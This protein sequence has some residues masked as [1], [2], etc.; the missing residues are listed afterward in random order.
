MKNLSILVIFL[1][2]CEIVFAGRRYKSYNEVY[3]QSSNAA[4]SASG[5]L[6]TISTGVPQQYSWRRQS[7][8]SRH[9]EE[10][11]GLMRA[12]LAKRFP[13][14]ESDY[15]LA[16]VGNGVRIKGPEQIRKSA[17]EYMGALL[18]A[19]RM[20]LVLTLDHYRLTKSAAQKLD[21]E[22]GGILETKTQ[23]WLK[24]NVGSA[25]NSE[26]IHKGSLVAV[27]NGRLI[28][29]NTHKRRYAYVHHQSVKPT[30]KF[31]NINSCM[32]A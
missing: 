4:I 14:R 21:S 18:V 31:H 8:S 23:K 20:E 10:I 1:F 17:Q 19:R 15:T 28:S 9:L 24:R 6:P 29:A 26:I 27:G 22:W 25:S 12:A 13:E 3:N 7:L 16:I 5:N 30:V 11:L 2:L 32:N